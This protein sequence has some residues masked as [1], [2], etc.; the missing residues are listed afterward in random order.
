MATNGEIR[1]PPAG[2]NNG[3][4][5]GIKWPRMGRNRWPLT[6]GGEYAYTEGGY[7]AVQKGSGLGEDGRKYDISGR[8][9][10]PDFEARWAPTVGPYPS[11][12]IVR[13]FAQAHGRQAQDEQDTFRRFLVQTGAEEHAALCEQWLA[14]RKADVI[15][16]ALVIESVLKRGYEPDRR[17]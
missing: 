13:A 16:D 11:T 3:H 7:W 4:Q 2:R 15:Q 1:W 5:W 8:E 14:L 10:N 17:R 6:G 12:D 9:S